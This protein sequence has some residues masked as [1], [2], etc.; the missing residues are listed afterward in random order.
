M[1]KKACEVQTTK[2]FVYHT[3]EFVFYR[4]RQWGVNEEYKGE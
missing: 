3:K 1:A 2:D 4:I